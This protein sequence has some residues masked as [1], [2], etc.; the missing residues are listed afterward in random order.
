MRCHPF[1]CH[2]FEAAIQARAVCF[3]VHVRCTPRDVLCETTWGLG[4][5]LKNPLKLED[6][7]TLLLACLNRIHHPKKVRVPKLPYT[8]TSFTPSHSICPLPGILA[9]CF[10]PLQTIQDLNGTSPDVR[11]FNC[12]DAPESSLYPASGVSDGISRATHSLASPARHTAK[13]ANGATGREAATHFVRLA[14]L[15][16]SSYPPSPS[17]AALF[18]AARQPLP[19]T[20]LL[21]LSQSSSVASA[22]L[23]PPPLFSYPVEFHVVDDRQIQTFF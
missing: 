19:P 14:M 3:F 9:S 1:L 18:T 10:I 12:S 5:Q 2:I 6:I 22:P 4:F 21:Q 8:S 23:S 17:S 16:S 7:L 20:R 11:W 13:D 15:S